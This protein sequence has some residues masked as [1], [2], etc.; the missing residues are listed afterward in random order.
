[1]PLNDLGRQLARPL[2]HKAVLALATEAVAAKQRDRLVHK[3]K[4]HGAQKAKGRRRGALSY[5]AEG[6][7]CS[8]LFY[9]EFAASPQAQP[10]T[11]WHLYTACSA[12]TTV[13]KIKQTRRLFL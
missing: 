7:W 13:G 9:K 1:M 8:G 11:W 3:R 4:A 5:L 12:C 10:I 6:G 2:L